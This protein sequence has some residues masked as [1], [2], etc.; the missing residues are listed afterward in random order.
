[1]RM[2]NIQCWK[3]KNTF[4]WDLDIETLNGA[5]VPEGTQN[6]NSLIIR[7]KTCGVK[8]KIHVTDL[9]TYPVRIF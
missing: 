4:Q 2:Q 9:K 6:S 5:I 7:C 8:V 1:M 3:C